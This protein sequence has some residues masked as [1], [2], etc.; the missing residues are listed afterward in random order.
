MPE[1]R[2]GERQWSVAA[3]SNLLDVLNQAGVAVPYSC[4]AGSCHACP[5]DQATK[6]NLKACKMKLEERFSNKIFGVINYQSFGTCTDTPPDSWLT[7]IRA[8]LPFN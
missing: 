4:R 3:G 2:V 7:L 1:L 6:D 5:F 8:K